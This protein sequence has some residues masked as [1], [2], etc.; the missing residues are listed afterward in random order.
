MT[1]ADHPATLVLGGGLMGLAVAHQLA[2]RGENV[3]VISRR[4]SE[5]AGFVA[6][7]ML[8]PHAR[9]VTGEVRG[10]LFFFPRQGARTQVSV[11][12]TGA[13][14]DGRVFYDIQAD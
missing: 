3:T 1:P 6:A 5:A 12:P 10:V 7:G 4:R 13:I 14:L 8:A 9:R 11:P 2:R